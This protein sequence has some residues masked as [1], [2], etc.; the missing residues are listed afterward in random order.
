MF[1]PRCNVAKDAR[2]TRSATA[3]IVLVDLRGQDTFVTHA[4]VIWNSS[5]R[6]R[7]AKTIGEA[8]C[9]AKLPARS[10]PL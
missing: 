6:L 3:G 8:R 5:A 4:A 9:V 1:G 10:A 7:S 2:P